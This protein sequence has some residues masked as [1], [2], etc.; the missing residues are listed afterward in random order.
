MV[1]VA[2]VG[3]F[4]LGV[5]A[6][7]PLMGLLNQVSNGG[8]PVEPPS[9]RPARKPASRAPGTPVAP[10]PG[11]DPEATETRFED[12]SSDPDWESDRNRSLPPGC[13]SVRQD[14]GARPG[15][16][17]DGDAREVGGRV[18]RT[19]Q[20]AYYAKPLPRA[21][22]LDDR[23]TF[24][25]TFDVERL[26]EAGSSGVLFGLF[27]HTAQDWRTPQSVA[28]RVFDSREE[29]GKVS[30]AAEYGTRAYR[31]DQLVV[32]AGG[33]NEDP[34]GDEVVAFGLRQPRR[35][36]LDYDPAAAGGRGRMTLAVEGVRTPVVLDLLPGHRGDGAVLDRF[37]M[38]NQQHEVSGSMDAYFGDLRLNGVP[39]AAERE[40]GWEGRGNRRAFRDCEV[41]TFHNFGFGEATAAAGGLVWRTDFEEDLSAWYG[42][43]DGV[44]LDLDEELYASGRVRLAWA[45]SD[46][47]VYLGWFG[48]DS[49]PIEDG[50][51]MHVPTNSVAMLVEGPS[52]V[53]W[54]ARPVYGAKDE[55]AFGFVEGAPGTPTIHPSDWREFTIHYD[56]EAG[57]HG[58]IAV[59]LDGRESRLP[60]SEDARDA[61]AD[62]GHFGIRTVE[63]DGHA[64]MPVFDDLT[65]TREG[66]D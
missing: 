1:A 12:F 49:E 36:R 43:G 15:G 6:A 21:L 24:E 9:P 25:G 54:Y 30:V 22:T 11:V 13:P 27:N 19:H 59:T 66:R 55:D 38:L 42:D 65:Y 23:F 31:T 64:M 41:E 14:F 2:L 34:E 51:P 44:S 63:D 48:K 3:V 45:N 35:F 58:E 16:E 7:E 32:S 29:P 33:G 5:V 10:P 62:L 57:E 50:G 20:T 40:P 28:I 26:S 52:E 61:G 18:F 4:A 39:V 37:G 46:S 47:G 56:P 53:G 8:P 17:G 60:V